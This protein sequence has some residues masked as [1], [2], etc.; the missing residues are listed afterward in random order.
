MCVCACARVQVE[1]QLQLASAIASANQSDNA[2]ACVS[3][4][5]VL[6]ADLD[7]GR[8]ARLSNEQS[9]FTCFEERLLEP[10]HFLHAIGP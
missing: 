6:N 4:M 3:G 1:V 10:E 5:A 8:Q 2:C 7:E 9:C